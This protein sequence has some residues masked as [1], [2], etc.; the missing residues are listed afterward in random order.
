MKVRDLLKEAEEQLKEA[1]V[2]NASY[3]ARIML[4]EAYGKTSA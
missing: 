2:P 3:D 4:E 1:G